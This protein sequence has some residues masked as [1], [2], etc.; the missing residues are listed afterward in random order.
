M[1]QKNQNIHEIINIDQ[2]EISLVCGG[3][4]FTDMLGYGSGVIKGSAVIVYTGAI[5]TYKSIG[6]AYNFS[7]D[8]YRE[9]SLREFVIGSSVVLAAIYFF[10][11]VAAV[12]VNPFPAVLAAS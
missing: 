2:E 9:I 1:I 6:F 7:I 3:G 11:L 10:P 12:P 4:R 5:A 8:T